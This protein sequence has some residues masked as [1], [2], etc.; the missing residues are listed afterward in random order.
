MT[1]MEVNA[2]LADSAEAVQGKIYALGIGWNTI[3]AE[4]FPATHPRVAVG[5]T[6]HVPYIATN[7]MHNV[8]LHLM[9]QDGDRVRI[10]L[11]PGAD[12][13]SPEPIYELGGQF[14]VGRPPLLPAGDDQV[15]AL[16]M[17]INGLQFDKPDMYSWIISIDGKP[18]KRLPMRVQYLV[19]TTPSAF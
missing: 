12:P 15:V 3:Y 14:N 9:H 18:A 2:F 16:A 13:G 6:I 7:Q 19:Q 11:K 17:T 1:I 8:T 5:V 10:G 4:N